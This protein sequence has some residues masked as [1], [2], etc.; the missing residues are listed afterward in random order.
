MLIYILGMV[1]RINSLFDWE[2]LADFME[3]LST[4]NIFEPINEPSIEELE[5]MYLRSC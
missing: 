3:P 1:S 2:R 4:L 5:R